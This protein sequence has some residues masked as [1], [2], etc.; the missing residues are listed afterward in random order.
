M[1]KR[2]RKVYL[3]LNDEEFALLRDC[4]LRFRNKLLAQGRYTD[5][6][7]ELLVKLLTH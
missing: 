2:D 5:P 6:V 7:D 4:L 3:S 1:F